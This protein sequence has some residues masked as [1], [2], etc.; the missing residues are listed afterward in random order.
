[1]TSSSFTKIVAAMNLSS[2]L[3]CSLMLVINSTWYLCGLVPSVSVADLLISDCLQVSFSLKQQRK[4]LQQLPEE[5][6]CEIIGSGRPV[7][8]LTQPF[9]NN[10]TYLYVGRWARLFT[11]ILSLNS[12]NNVWARH[13]CPVL[14]MQK[15]SRQLNICSTLINS[16]PPILPNEP[17][18]WWSLHNASFKTL[19]QI[20]LLP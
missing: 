15:R 5:Q 16:Q 14:P 12:P 20:I 13:Y 1:M 2:C 11:G 4:K 6:L 9:Q 3:N 7:K 17:V 8:N 10:I 18:L 19:E